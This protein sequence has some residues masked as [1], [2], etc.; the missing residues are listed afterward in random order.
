MSKSPTETTHT[1][2]NLKQEGEVLP[3]LAASHYQ[4]STIRGLR[5]ILLNTE[6][7]QSAHESSQ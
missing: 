3:T 2:E 7:C 4:P 1:T 6:L 5:L